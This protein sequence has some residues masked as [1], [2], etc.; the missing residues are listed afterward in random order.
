LPE[1]QLDFIR[2][3]TVPL[4]ASHASG[5]LDSANAILAARPEV[6]R[7]SIHTAAVLGDDATVRELLARDTT[8]A[9][10]KAGPHGWDALTHLCFSRYLRIDRGR[11]AGFLRAATALLEAGASARTG[12]WE[13]NHQ[14]EPEW[15][16]AL[17][18]AAG[19]AHDAELTRLLLEWGADPNDNETVYHTPESYDNAAMQALVETGQLTP[20]NLALMLVRKHD[21]HDLEGVRWLLEHGTDP[22][23]S[24]TGGLSPLHHAIARDNSLAIVELLLDHGADPTRVSRGLSAVAR[25]ARAGRSNLLTLFRARGIDIG[26]TGSDALIAACALDDG[27][28]IAALTL[29]E[30]ALVSQIVAMGPVLLATFAGTDNAPGLDRLLDLGIAVDATVAHPDGYWGVAPNST[31]LHVASWRGAHEAVKLLLAR[32]ASSSTPDGNGR[33]PLQLAVRACVDSYWADRRTTESIEALLGAGASPDEVK[34][35]TGYPE[36]DALLGRGRRPA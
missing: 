25:A 5:T 13:K 24:W 28:A 9:K 33:T 32:G 27:P 2:E 4:D 7:A 22:N 15:E 17:Y 10:Q 16:S 11:S 1:V 18:G 31:A 20:E 35:P 23:T 14:P 12:W 3:A 19:I 8:L 30:P 21:W 34:M 6:A 36:A 26:L 29:R